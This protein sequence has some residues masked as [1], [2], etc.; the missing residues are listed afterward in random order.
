MHVRSSEMRFQVVFPKLV[1]TGLKWTFTGESEAR[2]LL[3]S[4]NCVPILADPNL[5][6]TAESEAA[7]MEGSML[8]RAI[9]YAY[10]KKWIKLG[11]RIVLSQH[12]KKNTDW[13]FEEAGVVKII[14]V[15]EEVRHKEND[16]SLYTRLLGI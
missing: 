11:S 15:G 16:T 3:V 10:N 6:G 13:T 7:E 9:A 1:S 12:A 2:H 14:V 5:G 8:N 4:R